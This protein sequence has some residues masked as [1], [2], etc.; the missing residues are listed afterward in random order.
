MLIVI[1][2]LCFCTKPYCLESSAIDKKGKALLMPCDL[3]REKSLTECQNY[4]P[5][6]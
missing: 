2:Y 6:F 5:S 1:P 4:F 3:F